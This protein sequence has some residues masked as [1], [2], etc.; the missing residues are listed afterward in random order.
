MRWERY[1]RHSV[2]SRQVDHLKRLVAMMAVQDEDVLVVH[3]WLHKL[4]EVP[5][6][7]EEH[8]PICPTGSGAG[9]NGTRWRPVH[10]ASDHLRSA[11]DE[12]RRKIASRSVGRAKHRDQFPPLCTCDLAHALYSL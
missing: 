9:T 12:E 5:E 1:D 7:L 6:P 8:L 4:Q 10:E 2:F 3:P 11:E